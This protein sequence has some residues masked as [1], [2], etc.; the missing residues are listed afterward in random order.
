MARRAGVARLGHVA[1]DSTRVQANASRHRMVDEEQAAREERARDR[2]QVRR[3]Q[4]RALAPEPDEGAG[5][6]L[7]VAQPEVLEQ[8]LAE[9]HQGLKKLPK[10]G[11]RQ[12][13][14]TD[15]ES[16]FLRTRE[17]W[18]LGYTAD[19][20]VSDDHFIVAARV[21]QNAT[22]NAALLPLV[23]EVER[24]CGQ[25]P[26]R[27]TADAGFFSG[28]ALRE[29]SRRGI[30]LYVPDNNLRHEMTSGKAGGRNRTHGDSRSRTSADAGEVAQCGGP[31][32]VATKASSSGTRDWDTESTTRDAAGSTPWAGGGEHRMDHGRHRPQHRSP[33]SALRISIADSYRDQKLELRKMRRT[34]TAPAMTQTP[35]GRQILAQRFSAG[36]R[37][38]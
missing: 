10:A 16:R 31:E 37:P 18:V 33:A 14:A 32:D 13:S 6:E 17:G 26:A 22:D 25:R 24:Q 5:T 21:R 3:F 28:T 9:A 4:Q 19:I 7:A 12:V 36:T 11:R 8:Q 34:C 38:L 30:D 35:E 29:C 15:P 20:A 27:V 1:I 2:R 23:E